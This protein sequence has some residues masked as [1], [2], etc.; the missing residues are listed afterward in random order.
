VPGGTLQLTLLDPRPIAN[1][2]GP[3]MTAW[4][5]THL[6]KNLEA[7]GLCKNLEK[8]VAM[9]LLDA[10]FTG[11]ASGQRVSLRAVETL[12]RS[13]RSERLMET[14]GKRRDDKERGGNS[15]EGRDAKDVSTEAR[16]K[17]QDVEKL[18]VKT[19][20]MLWREIWGP[21]VVGEKWWWEDEEVLEECK[22]LGTRWE[23]V[24]VKAVTRA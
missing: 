2:T 15:R 6:L 3:C 21:W 19:A 24:F 7:K 5:K 16:E 1:T 23:V 9:W 18:K 13:E 12:E 4:L 20:R 17:A 14:D 8:A 10:G 22:A 11:G